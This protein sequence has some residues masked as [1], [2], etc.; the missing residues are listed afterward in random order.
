MTAG[1]RQTTRQPAER[2]EPHESG[3]GG[4]RAAQRR[5]LAVVLVGSSM[6]V[7]DGSTRVL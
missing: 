5:L 3:R 2:A 7:L 1:P 6:A 4:K